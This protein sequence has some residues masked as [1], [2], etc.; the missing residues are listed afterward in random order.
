[1]QLDDAAV[2]PPSPIQ[3]IISQSSCT[4]A[5]S[6]S[7]AEPPAAAESPAAESP[8]AE[9][10]SLS[11]VAEPAAAAA[12]EP[13]SATAA[14]TA[15]AALAEEEMDGVIS[16]FQPIPTTALNGPF[17]GLVG[18]GPAADA[19]RS[20]GLV[21]LHAPADAVTLVP[22]RTLA[23]V[24]SSTLSSRRGGVTEGTEATSQGSE[25]TTPG[26][27]EAVTTHARVDAV[28]QGLAPTPHAA[29]RR[30]PHDA[31]AAG[32]LPGGASGSRVAAVAEVEEIDGDSDDGGVILILGK[33][34]RKLVR[35]SQLLSSEDD[36]GDDDDGDSEEDAAF[37]A[38][39]AGAA[40]ALGG[41]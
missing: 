39:A 4:A 16:Y 9:L 11:S 38:Y 13:A 19:A 14:A 5:E 32:N 10:S 23:V 20:D 36:D 24:S 33:Q 37:A 40:A 3:S 17:D 30:D 15:A 6:S 25:A 21:W 7:A 1:V 8:G 29:P 26:S 22:A 12:A 2:E 27:S 34:G 35:I 18:V 41:G 28:R 31:A